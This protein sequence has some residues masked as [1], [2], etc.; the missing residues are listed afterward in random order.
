[1]KLAKILFNFLKNRKSASKDDEA[2][3]GLCPNCWGR[4]EYG[5]KFFEAVKTHHID[6]NSKDQSIGWI[7]D[8]ANKNL[9]AIELKREDEN[10]VCQKCKLTYHVK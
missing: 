7:Q 9:G 4:T 10:M 1:M 5:N 8:Y 2:P 6:V 3:E